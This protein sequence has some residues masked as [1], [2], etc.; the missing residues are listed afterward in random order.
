MEDEF[1]VSPDDANS[2][3]DCPHEIGSDKWLEWQREFAWKEYTKPSGQERVEAAYKR[4]QERGFKVVQKAF[5]DPYIPIQGVQRPTKYH[6]I[7]VT[8]RY[9]TFST[10][11]DSDYVRYQTFQM[12]F[13][14]RSRLTQV[15]P[16]DRILVPADDLR[17]EIRSFRLSEQVNITNG[18]V[19]YDEKLGPKK[20]RLACYEVRRHYPNTLQIDRALETLQDEA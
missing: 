4:L 15:Q 16:W 18:Y 5:D 12:P 3:A 10:E 20:G 14:K 13:L 17:V 2:R 11:I 7:C 1:Y 8:H 19:A 6:V 9:S